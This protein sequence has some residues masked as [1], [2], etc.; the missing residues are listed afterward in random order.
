MPTITLYPGTS[1]EFTRQWSTYRCT[2]GRAPTNDVQIDQ[3]LVSNFHAV[4]ELRDQ[5]YWIVDL[6]SSNGTFVNGASV[7]ACQLHEGDRVRLGEVVEFKFTGQADQPRPAP[8]ANPTARAEPIP[9]AAVPPGPADPAMPTGALMPVG[10]GMAMVPQGNVCPV[11]QS[12]IPFQVNFCP[13]CGNFVGSPNLPAIPTQPMGGPL[14]PY[15]RPMEAPGQGVGILP[16]LA[17]LCGL[18]VIGF[19]FAIVLGLVALSQIRRYGGF[20]ADRTQAVW[21]V[22][23]GFFW[24]VVLAVG[25]GW[26]GT[27]RYL[28]N[29]QD[30]L[31]KTIAENEAATVADLMG[32]ARAQ[33]YAKAILF[34]DP[35]QTGS[36]QYLS[37]DELAELNVPFFNQR[38]A[39]GAAHGYRFTI[40]DPTERNF[41]AVAEPARYGVTGKRTFSIEASGIVSAKD[42]EGR[43][44]AQAQETLQ[45]VAHLK[46]A[47][48]DADDA[49]AAEVIAH[50]RRL[51]TEGK[52]ELVG[53][54]LDGVR[55]HFVLT[56]SAQDLL[57]LRGTVDPFIIE[58]QAQTRYQN[59]LAAAAEGDYQLAVNHLNEI[60]QNYPGFSRITAVH[61]DL[62]KYQMVQAQTL[63]QRARAAGAEGDFRLA[64]TLLQ[65]VRENFPKF[66]AITDVVEEQG[67]FVAALEQQRDSE[68]R[69]LFTQAEAL[70]R[71]GNPKE[72]MDLFVQIEKNYGDTEW[73]QRIAE[74][75]PALRKQIRE[76]A[77]EELFTQAV[78]LA[79]G[80]DHR[81]QLNAIEQLLR[82]YARTDYV[83]LNRPAINSLHQKLLAEQYRALAVEQ[84]EQGKNHGALV[85]LEEAARQNPDLRPALKDLFA[86]LYLNVGNRRLNEG[87]DR[88]ALNLFRKYI[89]LQPQQ[90]EVGAELLARLS[91]SVAK[92]E[93]ALGN[94]RAAAQNMVSAAPY[95]ARH[96]EFRD[97]HGSILF[98]LGRYDDAL[99]EFNLAITLTPDNPNY[100]ARRGYTSLLI[101][102]QIQREAFNAFASAIQLP[103]VNFSRSPVAAPAATDSKDAKSSGRKTDDPDDETV[104]AVPREPAAL[105]TYQP[106]SG[107]A[108][109]LPL[110]ATQTPPEQQIRYDPQA[111]Q[112][113]RSEILNLI[114]LIAAAAQATRQRQDESPAERT[115]RTRM[116]RLRTGDDLGNAVSTLNQKVLDVA[117]RKQRTAQALRRMHNLFI[118]GNRDL[119]QA[120]HGGADR[121][122]ELTEILKITRQHERKLAD[123][124]ARIAG[125]LEI[126]IDVLKRSFDVAESMYRTMRVQ[127][128][129]PRADATPTLEAYF[130]RLYDRRSF[131]QGIQSLR[132][133][134]DLKV[135]LDL[136]S[137]RPPSLTPPATLRPAPAPAP[138]LA[139]SPTPS[140]EPDSFAPDFLP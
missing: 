111:A 15:V 73:A 81:E 91:F 52:Y 108:T 72:A 40:R 38:L 17:F 58:A 14:G 1:R 28:H 123:A 103:T 124:A 42:L 114:E 85:M 27:S 20:G 31:A 57:A 11:C 129:G 34:K 122:P 55:N 61:Q 115:S 3:E 88:E 80:D 37:L 10:Q 47:F 118:A 53:K 36:G 48:E 62:E 16:L 104:P 30:T 75:R 134:A 43:S 50:A 46:S 95:Y 113:L 121:S 76:K 54:L 41:L 99:R 44:F 6:N 5:Q 64:I 131:D 127:Q 126:E 89:A 21:G 117:N 93:Y 120:I 79:G 84:I 137:I 18:S 65:E 68:A 25:L 8:T 22:G 45:P 83:Q 140:P 101:A 49:I 60:I 97:L 56:K 77:A 9:P 132:E 26:Y 119:A 67:R 71:A 87:D 128:I 33:K 139:A 116:D 109:A 90:T 106:A 39:G 105:P 125:H 96:A 74:L 112:L 82:N 133:A 136:Y 78:N 63:Y 24:A 98:E 130:S 135:P 138:P 94:Y 13:R 12:F 7:K 23:L 107:F 19:P 100:H 69:A 86:R 35:N 51:A 92:S 66:T 2:I 70:E 32:I 4:I 110:P 29:R 59:A 102:L